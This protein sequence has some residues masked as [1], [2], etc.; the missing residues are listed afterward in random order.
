MALRYCINLSMLYTEYPFLDCF[1]KAARAGFKAVECFFPYEFDLTKVSA[2]L[3]NLAVRGA[4]GL[5]SAGPRMWFDGAGGAE[6]GGRESS[7]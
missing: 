4:I 3:E 2:R 6:S 7:T 5:I 1:A